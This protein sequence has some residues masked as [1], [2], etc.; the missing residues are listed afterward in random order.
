[1]IPLRLLRS[2]A[3]GVG[4]AFSDLR[5]GVS[6]LKT[7]VLHFGIYQ[8]GEGSMEGLTPPPVAP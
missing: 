8:T 1:M 7:G 2:A 4:A 3:A 5:I 6:E